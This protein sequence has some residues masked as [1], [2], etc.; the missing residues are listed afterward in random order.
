MHHADIIEIDV[1]RSADGT[2]LLMHD[3]TVERTTNGTGA[4]ADLAWADLHRLDAGSHFS[5]HCS[6]EVVPS[7]EE[8]LTL[9]KNDTTTLMIEVK[10]PL[11]A[12]GIAEQLATMIRQ[13]RM[14]QR[15]I[16]TSF[17]HEWVAYFHTVAPEIPVGLCTI[18]P[19][20]RPRVLSARMV[21]LFW[22]TVILDPTVVH[23]LHNAGHLVYVYSVNNPQLMR[24]LL[25][26]GV[27]GITT[28]RPDLWSHF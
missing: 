19:L 10:A 15:V 21:E 6:H 9:L 16:V 1:R 3:A 26:L 18:W 27:D 13:F 22:P 25:A 7:L 14:S 20:T 5:V 24:W 11:T 4:V 17:D 28:D 8:V 12:P 23:R 2:L